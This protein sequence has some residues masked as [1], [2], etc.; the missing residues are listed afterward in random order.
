MD[1]DV[2][3]GDGAGGVRNEVPEQERNDLACVL[4]AGRVG[5][6]DRGLR[7]GGHVRLRD[8]AHRVGA[9]RGDDARRAGAGGF[10]CF[11]RSGL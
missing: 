11:L 4:A 2:R 6:T 8:G 10:C 3:R 9:W 7:G 5:R 1:R